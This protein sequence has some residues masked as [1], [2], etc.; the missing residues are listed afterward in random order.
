[1]KLASG[2]EGNGFE[3]WRRLFVDYEGDDGLIQDDGRTRLQSFAPISST[4]EIGS[5][6]DDW[7]D[8]LR[9]YGDDIGCAT[10]RTMLLKPLPAAT[11]TEILKNG[12]L[13]TV[14][15]ISA[16]LRRTTSW[17]RTENILKKKH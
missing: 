15:Q 10:R 2:G 4:S 7:L 17:E 11:R 14:E 16:W 5:R 3:L 12:D 6:L 9:D 13:Q 1:M 8:L